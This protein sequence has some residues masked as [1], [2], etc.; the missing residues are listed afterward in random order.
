MKNEKKRKGKGNIFLPIVE[1][2]HF[3]TVYKVF[4]VIQV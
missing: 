2:Y 4:G 1:D 3:N